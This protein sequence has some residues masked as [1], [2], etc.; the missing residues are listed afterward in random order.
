MVE[1]A[2][3]ALKPIP[4]P[5]SDDQ[6]TAPADVTERP[7]KPRVAVVEEPSYASPI[8]TSPALPEADAVTAP[9]PL[10]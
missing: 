4:P 1:S 5:R 9:V 3:D 6:E 2:Y 8:D 10:L 7:S